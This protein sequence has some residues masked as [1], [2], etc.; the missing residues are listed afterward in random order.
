MKRHVN[1]TFKNAAGMNRA[2]VTPLYKYHSLIYEGQS[3]GKEEQI[4]EV[5]SRKKQVTD[6]IPVQVC[7]YQQ[8]F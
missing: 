7:F 5:V 1:V 2:L 3:N 8:Y 6:T 4:F